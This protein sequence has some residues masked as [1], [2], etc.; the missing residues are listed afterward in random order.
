MPI[1]RSCRT[2]RT[3]RPVT[4][5]TFTCRGSTAPASAETADA[6][7]HFPAEI[8]LRIA[9]EL[10]AGTTSPDAAGLDRLAASG[11]PET[12]EL[13]CRAADYDAFGIAFLV[14]MYH[15]DV[16][17]FTGA[18][19]RTDGFLFRE[20]LRRL[21]HHVP[22]PRRGGMSI[23]LSELGAEHT[24]LGAARLYFENLF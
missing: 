17:I 4:S 6:S 7:K 23:A 19:C 21:D 9:R 13:L 14:Q 24:A 18:Q 12:R 16:L 2:V 22:P 11:D 3:V 15:P 10:H 8:P 1:I 20:L 5:D